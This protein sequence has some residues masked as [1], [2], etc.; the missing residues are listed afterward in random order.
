[1]HLTSNKS[2]I[3]DS[4]DPNWAELRSKRSHDPTIMTNQSSNKRKSKKK[5]HALSKSKDAKTSKKR[6]R[7]VVHLINRP[8]LPMLFPRYMIIV[9]FY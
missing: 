6:G 3:F 7:K 5:V 2:R 9:V 1:M 4:K 8:T